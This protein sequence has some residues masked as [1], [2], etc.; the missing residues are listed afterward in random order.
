MRGQK[1][2]MMQRLLS[3]S[4][5]MVLVATGATVTT[6]VAVWAAI[7]DSPGGT[8]HACYNRGGLLNLEPGELRVIDA[9]SE[10]C[11]NGE[12][13][14][15][16]NQTGPQGPAGAIGAQGPKGDTGA[17]GATGA[18]GDTGPAGPAGATGAKGDTGATGPTGAK[19]D[20]GATGAKGDTGVTGAT[21][22]QGPTGPT[23]ATGPQ[24]PAGVLGFNIATKGG[25]A[26]GHGFF[27]DAAVCPAGQVAVGGGAAM[28]SSPAQGTITMVQSVPQG[29]RWLVDVENNGDAEIG[30]FAYA[31]CV[32]NT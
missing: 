21:G 22:P 30:V 16:W 20:T 26:P 17:T 18:K 28:A 25:T 8:I 32:N 5:I 2:K 29:N 7:P 19:G 1:R 11:R 31:T 13:A 3:R 27:F 23:G 24:G 15:T 4:G 12:T 6:G 10:H 14:L 9:A